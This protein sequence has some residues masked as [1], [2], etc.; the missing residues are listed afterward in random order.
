MLVLDELRIGLPLTAAQSQ[1][2]SVTLGAID[3]AKVTIERAESALNDALRDDDPA[4][5]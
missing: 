4:G 2:R 5:P 1:A 3:E